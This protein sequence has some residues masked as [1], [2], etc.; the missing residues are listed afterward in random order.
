MHV[1][2]LAGVEIRDSVAFLDT[3]TVGDGAAGMQQCFR[4]LGFAGIA[5]SHQADI[6]NVSCRVGHKAFGLLRDNNLWAVASRRD[7]NPKNA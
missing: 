6:A 5:W 3:A 7:P 2:L 1:L 4:E